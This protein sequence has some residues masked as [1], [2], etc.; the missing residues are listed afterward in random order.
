VDY[1]VMELVEGEALASRLER[2]PLT[3]AEAIRVA[4]ELGDALDAAHRHGVVHRD[5]K[6]GNDGQHF[7]VSVA[8]NRLNAAP[9]P[10]TVRLNWNTAIK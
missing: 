5:L 8:L 10:L 1:L 4:S 6:P 2:G 7:L 9:T 3:V